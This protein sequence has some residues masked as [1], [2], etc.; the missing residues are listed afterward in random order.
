MWIRLIKVDAGSLGERKRESR[1]QS[2]GQNSKREQ[3]REHFF[4]FMKSGQYK[5]K[6][7]HTRQDQYDKPLHSVVEPPKQGYI[8]KARFAS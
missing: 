6:Q 8:H 4:F 3:K 7:I 1:P 2:A 5:P